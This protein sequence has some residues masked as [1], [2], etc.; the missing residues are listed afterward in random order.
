MT[1]PKLYVPLLALSLAAPSAGCSNTA[2]GAA[3]GAGAGGAAG[4]GIGAAIS[5][6]GKGAAIGALVGAVVG[7]ATGAIIG[8]VMDDRAAQIEK[9]LENARI[10]RVGEGILV[11]FSSGILF[12]VGKADLKPAAMKN[13]EELTKVLERYDDVDVLIAGHTDSTGNSDFNHKLSKERAEAVASYAETHGVSRSRIKLI[14]EGEDSPVA[15][16]DTPDGRAQ[17]RRVEIAIYANDKLRSAAE[18]K[19]S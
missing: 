13:I 14:G 10:E 3:I 16:N 2:R 9:D 18:K 11:T 4:A 8:K 12:D 5:K 15:S 17:N 7:G 1:A 19:A 6:S